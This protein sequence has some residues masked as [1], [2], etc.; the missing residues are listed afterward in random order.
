M[1]LTNCPTNHKNA[2]G[3]WSHTEYL[4]YCPDCGQEIAESEMEETETLKDHVE[5]EVLEDQKR[6]LAQDNGFASYKDYEE[7]LLI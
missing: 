7:S 3:G 1:I 5:G 2:Y 6:E 4:I